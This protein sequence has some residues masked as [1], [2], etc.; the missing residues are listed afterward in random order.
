MKKTTTAIAALM[1]ITVMAFAQAFLVIRPNDE[2]FITDAADKAVWISAEPG[3]YTIDVA[4]DWADSQVV[5]SLDY[6][7]FGEVIYEGRSGEFSIA[8]KGCVHFAVKKFN[9][10]PLVFRVEGAGE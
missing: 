10:Y 2:V 5:I 4:C 6:P 3:K 1:L 8:N 7:N 9:G